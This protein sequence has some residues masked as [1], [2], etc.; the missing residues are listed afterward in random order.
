[1]TLLTRYLL[2]R[3]SWPLLGSLLFYGCLL[4]ANETVGLSK[5]IFSQGAPLRWLLPLLSSTLPWILGMVLPMA[6]V[7]GGVLGTQHLLEGSELVAAQGLGAGSR[8]WF[9]PW[10]ILASVLVLLG[11][12]N[13]HVIVPAMSG[14]QKSFRVRMAEEA[15]TRFLRPGAPP[16][17]PPGSPETAVWVDPKGE[18]HLMESTPQGIRH[19]VSTSM[20]YA[21]LEKKDGQSQLEL[22]LDH[23]Q[24]VLMQP[25]GQGVVHLEQERQVLRFDLPSAASLLPPT[26]LRDRGSF[27][28][29]SMRS[30]LQ[31]RLEL[32][33]RIAIPLAAAALLL[34]GIALG[35][36]HPRFYR[37]GAL[38]KSMG[39]IVLYYLILTFF[40]NSYKGG[41]LHTVMP[42]LALPFAF[43]GAG[44][45]LLRRR[46]HPHRPSSLARFATHQWREAKAWLRPRMPHFHGLRERFQAWRLARHR[47]RR[48]GLLAR[49]AREAWFGNWASTIGSLLILNFLIEYANLA[50]DMAEHKIRFHVFL[51]Y[52]AWSLPPFLTVALPMS[53]LLGTVLTLSEAA[54]RL[55]WTALRAGGVSLVQWVWKARWGWIPVLGLTLLIQAL[56]APK[57]DGES[58]RLY[59]QILNRPNK[60]T[61]VKPWLYLGSTGVLW[62]LDSDQRWGF[63]LK[64][65]G[66]APILLRWRPGRAYSQVLAWNG[67]ELV[68]GPPADLL[69]PARALREAPTPEQA[70][71]V[72]LF[73]WQKW[74]PD[75]ERAHLLWSRLLGWLAGPCLA[76]AMLSFAFPGPRAGRGQALGFGL[77]GGLLY[78]GLQ[79]LFGGA[80]RAGEIAPMWGVLAPFVLLLGF[81]L[82]RLPRL[83]T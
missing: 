35:F 74:A 28:L 58:R 1:M 72:D 46:L 62:H 76:L 32:S 5:E 19:I 57:A 23:L 25:S 7:L 14:L 29:W 56:V 48:S 27:D 12:L 31:A 4:L 43:M 80:A 47:A 33:R 50:G 71:T 82:L 44:W 2:R 15:R 22:R 64:S 78:L 41:K 54:Q 81:A 52:W 34:L 61:Q 39:V 21:L 73:V 20:S 30:D 59:Q 77:V 68:Q 67:L 79:T 55:E 26:P 9:R 38:L 13:A 63:P 36:G 6:A 65:P 51:A 49:W 70:S 10:L 42:M 37:G 40:E 18:V 66:E 11:T 69:F 83:R 53:F 45:M 75:P 17:F 60:V 3:W 8:T 24:G 16:W